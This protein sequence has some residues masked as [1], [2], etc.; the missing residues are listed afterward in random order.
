MLRAEESLQIF[1]KLPSQHLPD[2]LPGLAHR[3]LIAQQA[4]TGLV[5]FGGGKR[6]Q[7]FKTNL[8]PPH[9]APATLKFRVFATDHGPDEQGHIVGHSILAKKEIVENTLQFKT[10]GLKGFEHALMVGEHLCLENLQIL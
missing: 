3:G 7:P 9:R 10:F 2:G 8:Y 6:Q 5:Q 1:W 4:Q